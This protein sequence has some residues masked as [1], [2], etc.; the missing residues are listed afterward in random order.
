MKSLTPLVPRL[1]SFTFLT[2]SIWT[3]TAAGSTEKVLYNF[4]SFPH[5]ESP[6]ANLIADTAGNLYGT[7]YVGGAY[8][9]GTVFKLTLGAKGW[10]QTVLYSFKGGSD[11]EY[12]RS[13][14][15]FDAAGNLYG[16]TASGGTSTCN[17]NKG[18][19]GTVFK[20]APNSHSGWTESLIY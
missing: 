7:T 1:I 4:T 17:G 19:C 5:G 14:L 10:T 20:L 12:P 3:A 13:R 8:Q 18:G 9:L 11:G 6:Q 2:L 15:V 16:T